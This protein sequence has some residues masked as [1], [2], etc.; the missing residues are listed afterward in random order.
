MWSPKGHFNL[1]LGMRSMK[2]GT[3]GLGDHQTGVDGESVG[4]VVRDLTGG[5]TCSI[6]SNEDG[7]RKCER[8]SRRTLSEGRQ[9]SRPVKGSNSRVT[10][11][12][13]TSTEGSPSLEGL[14]TP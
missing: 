12:R 9:T 13:R 8:T 5:V 6:G 7:V 4:E 3:G 14:I 11:H 10:L 1:I 2:K